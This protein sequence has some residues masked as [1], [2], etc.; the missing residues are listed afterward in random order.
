MNDNEKKVNDHGKKVSSNR[1]ALKHDCDW[2]TN[3]SY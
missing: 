3:G 2:L 1:N